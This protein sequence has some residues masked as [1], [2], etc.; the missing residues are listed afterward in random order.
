MK[1]KPAKSPSPAVTE[2]SHDLSHLVGCVCKN[3]RYE[4]HRFNSK[5]RLEMFRCDN[6][7]SNA[8]KNPENLQELTRQNGNCGDCPFKHINS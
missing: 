7:K 4:Y 5:S 8:P 6:T 3:C 1:E 2:Y